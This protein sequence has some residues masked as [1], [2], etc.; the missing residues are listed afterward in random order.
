MSETSGRVRLINT[1]ARPLELHLST[2]VVVVAARGE[3]TCDAL[4][5][6]AGQVKSLLQSG[7]MVSRA[8]PIPEPQD[9]APARRAGTSRRP[10]AAPP[11]AATTTRSRRSSAASK[12]APAAKDPKSHPA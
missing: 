5:A 7:V 10:P 1:Q 9:A 11:R 2:G 8:A 12:A 3:V 4:E 6:Q